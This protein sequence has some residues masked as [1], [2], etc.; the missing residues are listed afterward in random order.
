MAHVS[1]L[2]AVALMAA[3]GPALAA[4]KLLA[5][6]H[7]GGAELQ[8]R[9]SGQGR[10]ELAFVS[11]PGAAPRVLSTRLPAFAEGPAL[12]LDASGR[13]AAV[14]G[15]RGGL[16]SLPVAAPGP[17]ARVPGTASG[18]RSASLFRGRL[19][20]QR[21]TAVA[22]TSLSGGGVHALWRS[23]EWSPQEIAA[24]AHGSVGFV[25]ARD[26]AGNG[27]WELLLAQP[28][29]PVRRLL[30]LPLGDT[31]SGSLHIEGVGTD[32]RRLEV[33]QTLDSAV[34]HRSF[35]L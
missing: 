21:A 32:G 29:R 1:L 27:A 34:S 12:G 23:T 11:A 20:F 9:Q 33:T 7:Y 19:A 6:A 17:L 15:G 30:S 18:D 22:V 10:R 28:G 3:P 4:P 2:A 31:H 35:A 25:A 24:G 13:L 5:T 8:L 14:V 16:Y 26:G